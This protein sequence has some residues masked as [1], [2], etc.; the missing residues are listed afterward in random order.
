MHLFDFHSFS[1]KGAGSSHFTSE[2][3]NVPCVT[4]VV[5][6]KAQIRTRC[7]ATLSGQL[8]TTPYSLGA[9]FAHSGWRGHGCVRNEAMRTAE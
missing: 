7:L 2:E 9:R 5:R 8:L 4:Q 3:I 1:N 6:S